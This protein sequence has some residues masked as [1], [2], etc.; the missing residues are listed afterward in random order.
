M[1]F[2]TLGEHQRQNERGTGLGLSISKKLIEMMGGSVTVESE[3]GKGTVFIIK[4]GTKC[5]LV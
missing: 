1:D 5:K 4:I 3:L 2:Q